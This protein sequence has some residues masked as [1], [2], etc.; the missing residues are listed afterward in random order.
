M[1]LLLRLAFLTRVPVFLL[2]DSG[3][4]HLPAW[5]L[6]NG[7]GFDISPRRTPGYPF[8]L[9]GVIG[10]GGEDLYVIALV[11]HLLGLIVAGLAYLI[12]RKL[13]GP[14][15][16]LVAALI[17]ALEGT[18]LVAEHYIMPETLFTVFVLLSTWLMLLARERMSLKLVLV[19]GLCIGVAALIR[20]VGLVLGPIAGLMLLTGQASWPRR[21]AT[22]GVLATGAALIVLPWMGRNAVVQGQ[23]S[24][25]TT[26][27]KSLLAR[28]AKHDRGFTFFN[29]SKADEYTDR[30]EAQARQIIQSAINQRLSDGEI[31]DRLGERLRL[32]EPEVDRLLRDLTTSVILEKPMYFV[33]TSAEFTWELLVGD[34]ERLRTDWKSQNARLTRDEWEDRVAHLLG[35][36]SPLQE[37]EFPVSEAL[38]DLV[39]PSRL[40]AL[41]PILAVVGAALA[42]H[43]I[44][45]A[46]ALPA[47]VSLLLLAAP[48][49]VDGPVPR[50][51]YPVDPLIT[52]LAF[53]SLGAMVVLFGA[54]RRKQFAFPRGSSARAVTRPIAEGS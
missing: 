52:L 51:R 26:L 19:L 22:I 42:V 27:P 8:F 39:Q 40:G 3:G 53:G 9:A 47:V 15:I 2:R 31:Y 35:K 10:L 44:G 54:V 28:T 25:S 7:L 32:T 17:V 50:Y 41:L 48:A 18:L 46:G 20:P 45:I 29:Q 4:Y 16:A 12:A 14:P 23:A 5:D 13:F 6:A 34:V 24:M 38:V 30:R 36:A 11:Q 21:A 1:G 33:Q 43:R 49:T 37:A